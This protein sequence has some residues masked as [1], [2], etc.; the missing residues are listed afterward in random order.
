[1]VQFGLEMFDLF[2][3]SLKFYVHQFFDQMVAFIATFNEDKIAITPSNEVVSAPPD[4]M[5]DV[6]QP[7]VKPQKIIFVKPGD[8]IQK[9]ARRYYGDSSRWRDLVDLNQ[10]D[11]K[12]VTINGTPVATVHIVP[13]QELKLNIQ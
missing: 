3:I 2:L 1:M 10:L 12:S 13:G 5:P 7:I 9:I 6:V 4:I 8:T 11:V